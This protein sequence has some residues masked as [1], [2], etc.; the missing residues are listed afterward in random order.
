MM[1]YGNLR[2]PVVLVHGMFGWGT[3]KKVYET[4]PYWGATTGDLIGWLDDCGY[5]CYAATVGPLSSAWDQACELY[6]QLKGT[7]V[8]Y[9]EAHSKK[10]NHKRFG[11]TYKSTLVE[12]WSGENKIHLVGH[13][14][15]GNCVRLLAHLLANGAP[16]EVE[17]SGEDVSELFKGG[18]SELICSVTSLCASL[19]GTDAYETAERFKILPVLISTAFGCAAIIAKTPLNG[20][21]VDV[22]LEQ[23]GVNSIPGEFERESGLKPLLDFLDNPDNVKFDMSPEGAKLLN[24][25]ID[26]SKDN[27]YFSYPFNVV[28]QYKNTKQLVPVGVNFKFLSFTSTLMLLNSRLNKTKAETND[29]LVELSAASYP[30]KEP[31]VDYKC[32]KIKRASGTLCR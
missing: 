8:D 28:H 19:N 5:K 14:F 2:Y 25:R 21:L 4:L 16:E 12:N 29:G 27:Y 23:F 15:G 31:H 24:D 17:A 18:N 20:E 32:G 7:R 9:G 26:I 11:R 13:S 22:Q 1:V 10:Y 6:A 3:S 30:F